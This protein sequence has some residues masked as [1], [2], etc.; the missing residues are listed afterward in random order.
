MQLFK[1]SKANEVFVPEID[2]EHRGIFRIAGEISQA[3][4]SGSGQERMGELLQNLLSGM[5]DHFRHE[6]RLMRGFGYPLLGWHKQLHD[7]VRK[8]SKALVARAIDGDVAATDELLKFMAGWLKDH[9]AVADRMMGAY[10][11]NQ[12]R[13]QHALAS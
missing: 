12:Q 7:G 13:L 10:L 6:E 9:T 2:A 4:S 5:E 8:R 3:A 1:W 11:R